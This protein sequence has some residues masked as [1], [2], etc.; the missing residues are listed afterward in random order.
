MNYCL[1]KEIIATIKIYSLEGKKYVKSLEFYTT[2]GL[3]RTNYT[4]WLISVFK[5]GKAGIDYFPAPENVQGKTLRYRLRFYLGIDFSIG[6][7]LM[8][9]RREALALRQT[10]TDKKDNCLTTEI[11]NINLT[12]AVYPP[13][14]DVK[15]ASQIHQLDIAGNIVAKY[16]S[17]SEASKA[18][19]I[20]AGN[21][22]RACS[23]HLKTTNGFKWECV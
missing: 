1:N 5:L 21:I 15:F 9:K 16:V 11:K 6:L 4:T 3:A 14:K 2:T 10:L 23:G 20:S 8:I 22:R 13:L 19:G 7:C 17:V 12:N 18:T